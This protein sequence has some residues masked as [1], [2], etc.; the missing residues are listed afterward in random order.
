MIR[1]DTCYGAFT[2]L[3][4][5]VRVGKAKLSLDPVVR[6]E[7]AEQRVEMRSAARERAQR[8]KVDRHDPHANHPL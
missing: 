4:A 1:A 3:A 6:L 8:I 7:L 5:A 2:D